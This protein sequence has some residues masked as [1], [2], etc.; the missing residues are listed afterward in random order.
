V[1]IDSEV[2]FAVQKLSLGGM[3]IETSLRPEVNDIYPMEVSLKEG[4]INVQGRIAYVGPAARP[5]KEDV[6]A[7]RLGIEFM[8]VGPESR[9]ALE[10]FITEMVET[11]SPASTEQDAK[12]NH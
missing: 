1:T 6:P 3:L 5:A 12:P 8:E 7:V 10:K 9:S 2:E 11:D 4:R